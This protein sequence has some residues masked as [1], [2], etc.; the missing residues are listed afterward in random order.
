MFDLLLNRLRS[1][2]ADE[3]LV[4]CMILHIEREFANSIDNEEIIEEF[5]ISKPRRICI[6]EGKAHYVPPD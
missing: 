5:K 4:D 6:F 2:I 1:T 3:F